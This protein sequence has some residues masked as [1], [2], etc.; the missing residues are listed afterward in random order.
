MQR[1]LDATRARLGLVEKR[2]A[3][4]ENVDWIEPLRTLISFSDKA[5]EY[6]RRGN[7]EQ[8]RLILKTTS[9]NPT[10][11]DQILNIEARKPFVQWGQNT[12]KSE[13][14]RFTL[15]VR[16]LLETAREDFSNVFANIRRIVT[17]S[18]EPQR[19]APDLR[20]RPPN[21]HVH[22]RKPPS[23]TVHPSTRRQTAD[24]VVRGT[25]VTRQ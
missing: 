20:R 10:L 11:S 9:S 3:L 25:G 5:V 16:T 23:H 18:E 19:A 13:M 8:K 6:F 12:T 15:D 21:L 14:R 1:R 24:V 7:N 22:P 2:D 4:V 17:A